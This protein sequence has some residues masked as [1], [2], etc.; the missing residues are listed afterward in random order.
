MP[1]PLIGLSSDIRQILPPHEGVVTW[2]TYVQALTMAGA[3][4]LI[5]PPL[6][7]KAALTVLLDRLDGLV[8]I[9]GYDLPPA[10]YGQEAHP[11]TKE[12]DAR[13]LEGDRLL[14][15][16]ALERELPILAI[17]LGCQLLNVVL[18]GDLIQDIPSQV[19]TDIL[20]AVPPIENT[21]NLD[22]EALRDRPFQTFH[23]VTVQ[24]HTR[25]ASILGIESLEVNSSHHQALN[26][27]GHGLRTVA[28]A[29]DGIIEAVESPRDRFLL[30]VQWH[31]ERI[32]ERPVQLA[33]FEALVEAARA[34]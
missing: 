26:R 11:H 22:Q 2:L 5:I 14:A 20:H 25:L 29:P 28:W 6:E 18:G 33:L 32:T 9:G 19:D 4:P 10:W 30:A 12:A 24:P 16:L 8:F 23:P 31:P 21:A 34:S 27:L 1:P 7:E 3:A 15:E 17:C 13:R